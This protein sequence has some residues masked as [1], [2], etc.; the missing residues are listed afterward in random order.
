MDCF[1]LDD[2]FEKNILDPGLR[3]NF[4][5]MPVKKRTSIIANMMQNPKNDPESWIRACVRGFN[6]EEFVRKLKA[7]SSNNQGSPGH[8]VPSQQSS[9]GQMARS[10]QSVGGEAFQMPPQDILEVAG[11]FEDGRKMDALRSLMNNLNLAAVGGFMDLKPDQQTSLAYALCAELCTTSTP[12]EQI[13]LKWTEN[14][15]RIR[16]NGRG[17]VASNE[18]GKPKTGVTFQFVFAGGSAPLL[19]FLYA[20]LQ[21]MFPGQGQYTVLPPIFMMLDPREV[22]D[23]LYLQKMIP[24]GQGMENVESFAQLEQFLSGKYEQYKSQGVHVV[25][26]GMHSW[27]VKWTVQRPVDPVQAMRASDGLWLNQWQKVVTTTDKALGTKNVISI[28]FGH[29]DLPPECM[30]G[31]TRLFGEK[32]TIPPVEVDPVIVRNLPDIYTWTTGVKYVKFVP[33]TMY[34]ETQD[35]WAFPGRSVLQRLP[36]SS[37]SVFP[38]IAEVQVFKERPLN[39]VETF[40]MNSLTKSLQSTGQMCVCDVQFFLMLYGLGPT[41]WSSFLKNKKPCCQSIL[42]NTGLASNSITAVPCG[43]MR[44]CFTCE[45]NVTTIERGYRLDTLVNGVAAVVFRHL[46]LS[47]EGSSV[48]VPHVGNF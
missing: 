1:E 44:L 7:G 37:G 32:N 16:R 24:S 40:I 12:K 25:F 27:D 41:P 4:A 13:L 9:P 33:V 42:P 10:P 11:A 36:P 23:F 21:K 6:E 17:D 38:Q 20:V 46:A 5:K 47:A 15:L 26:V 29:A 31:L 28:F 14:L 43:T 35:G 22:D 39:D 34:T 48:Q 18:G 19:V 30:A 45:K 8:A 3:Q 2:Y